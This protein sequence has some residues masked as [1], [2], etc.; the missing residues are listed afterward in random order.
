[1]TGTRR[2]W[3]WCSPGGTSESIH[4]VAL[5]NAATHIDPAGPSEFQQF[6]G[7]K[8]QQWILQTVIVV[9]ASHLFHLRRRLGTLRRRCRRVHGVHRGPGADGRRDGF[10]NGRSRG[11]GAVGVGLLGRH[12]H[13]GFI[14]II[15]VEHAPVTF[16][17]TGT[18]ITIL[19][20]ICE[21]RWVWI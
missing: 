10:S 16:A 9:L 15:E 14:Q 5:F 7:R 20:R 6:L 4:N 18:M 17:R 3:R 2:H 11:G 19:L 1:M 21:Q 8:P 12:V 13:L